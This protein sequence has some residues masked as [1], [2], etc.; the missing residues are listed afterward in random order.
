MSSE[1]SDEPLITIIGNAILD[2]LD[3]QSFSSARELGKLR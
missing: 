1:P 2:A 3:K